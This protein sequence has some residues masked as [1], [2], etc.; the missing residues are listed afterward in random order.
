VGMDVVKTAIETLRGS[1]EV[2]SHPGQGTTITLKLPLT[3]AIIDGLLVKTGEATYVMP[4]SAIEECVEFSTQD[5]AATHGRNIL[6]IRGQIVPFVEMRKQF[7]IDG[8]RPSIEQIVINAV[9]GHRVGIV[10][11]RVIGEHQIVI[12]TM[13]RLYRDVEAISGASILGDGS[14]ALI[15]DVSKLIQ[16]L[17][18]L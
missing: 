13:S 8:D 14:V 18:A 10:V 3:L 16:N 7:K 1:V 9:D 12:K 6:N 5:R 17:D 4:L 15:L 11:D 2:S